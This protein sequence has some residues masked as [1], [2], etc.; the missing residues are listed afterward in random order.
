MSGSIRM[1]F[2]AVVL[3]LSVCLP[4]FAFDNV[5]VVTIDTLRADY[6]G[7]Y[8]SNK[9]KTP[10]LDS[11]AAGGVLF[12]NT[13]S[14]IPF[15]LPSHVSIFTGLIPPTHGV[16]DNGGFY[17]DRKIPTMSK[18]F[19]ERGLHTAAFVGGFPLDS[20]FGLDQGF[21][22]YDDGYPTRSNVSEIAMPE[23]K[24]SEVSDAALNWLETQK[25]NHWFCWVHFYDPHFPYRPPDEFKRMYP[26]DLY[27][28]EIAYADQ[29]LGRLLEFLKKNNLDKKT[30]ILLVSDH[31]E[32]L[33]EH[34]EKTHG[35]FAYEN[36]LRVPLILAP[37]HHK[38]ISSRVR[39]ID[40][41]PTV[42]AIQKLSF[43]GRVQGVS[44]A[45]YLDPKEKADPPVQDSYFEALSMYFNV[46]WA[47][48]RGFYSRNY[49]YISLPIRELYDLD[50]DP[51]ETRNLCEDK[52]LCNLWASRFASYFRPYN[53]PQA[54]P[55][56]VDAETAERLRALGYVAGGTV[57]KEEFT[58]EDDPKNMIR[59]H[60]RVDEALGFYQKGY[61]LK[62]LDILDQIMKEKPDYSIAYL[63]ASFIQSENGFP[64]KAVELL[65]K[66]M[67]NGATGRD[68]RA[69]LGLYLYEEK[70]YDD[71]ITVL[72]AVVN[73]EP[74]DL[75]NLN[76]LGMAYSENANYV[77]AEKTFQRA[78]SVDPTD[79]MT[80]NNLGTLYLSQKK[81]DPAIQKFEAAVASNPHIANAYNG[82]GVAY[83]TRKNWEMAIKNWSL[84]L[85]EDKSNFDAMLNLAF[86]YLEKDN[87]EKAIPLFQEFVKS[88]PPMRYRSDLQ[89]ARSI[90]RQLQ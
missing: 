78:L 20:R 66:A 2:L 84:A 48:L 64:G 1:K 28:G 72:Q 83:A 56:P 75:D 24:A 12:K 39:L 35:I 25:G 36:T 46:Q 60:N 5:L 8:G 71:A 9:V 68:I 49:K 37:F 14:A 45:K 85:Q 42:L 27:A 47:P 69:K 18:V 4:A 16:E 21:D 29:Q 10:H 65:K 73:E 87:R 30:L 40:V 67:E 38:V 74:K 22:L 43:P 13:V 80:L 77:E 33:G 23:R 34:R 50:K 63:H 19:K 44:L 58:P 41:A 62:A 31:G 90:I 6:V 59:I 76:Y 15:T 82:L 70:K 81:Y 57:L 32:S 7:A 86:A 52:Q 55:A 53:R 61:D 11:L 17:L 26:N 89:K 54:A 79:G 88:A 3:L 51:G